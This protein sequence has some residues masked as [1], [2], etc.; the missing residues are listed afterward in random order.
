MGAKVGSSSVP[1]DGSLLKVRE[2]LYAS[3]RGVGGHEGE[4]MVL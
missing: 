2:R 3:C 4:K 1:R